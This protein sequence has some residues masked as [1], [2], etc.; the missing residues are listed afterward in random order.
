MRPN[1]SI[2]CSTTE[3]TDS[4]LVTSRSRYVATLARLSREVLRLVPTTSK[5]APTRASAAALPMPEDA[6]V[7]SA[8]GRVAVIMH[9]LLIG[10]RS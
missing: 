8:T 3:L 10:L 7:T 5:P 4:S 6:P 1:R 2:T 9:S